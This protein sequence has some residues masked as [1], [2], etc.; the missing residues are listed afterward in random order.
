MSV[1][2]REYFLG[3]QLRFDDEDLKTVLPFAPKG[4]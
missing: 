2:R 1:D 3:M 4:P